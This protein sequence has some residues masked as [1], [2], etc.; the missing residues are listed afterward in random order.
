MA[1]GVLLRWNYQFLSH[2]LD[3][4]VVSSEE[5][6]EIGLVDGLVRDRNIFST[7]VMGILQFYA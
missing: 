4:R 2:E 7:L 6:K 5:E 1:S 3:T